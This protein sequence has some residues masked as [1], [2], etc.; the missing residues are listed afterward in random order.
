MLHFLAIEPCL[1]A[2]ILAFHLR[3][4]AAPLLQAR[5]V[6]AHRHSGLTRFLA[7]IGAAAAGEGGHSPYNPDDHL[8]IKEGLARNH[9]PAARMG[10]RL[11]LGSGPAEPWKPC[12]S[13]AAAPA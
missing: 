9:K 10:R 6:V 4:S 12:W 8:S 7:G 1:M 5:S 11:I 2:T 13:R 3:Y